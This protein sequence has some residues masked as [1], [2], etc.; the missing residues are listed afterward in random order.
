MFQDE[1]IVV[2]SGMV[3]VVTHADTCTIAIFRDQA[4]YLDQI[5][6]LDICQCAIV[7]IQEYPH[8]TAAV[9]NDEGV[10]AGFANDP[11][12]YG[13]QP[14]LVGF[15]GSLRS[16]KCQWDG[17][18]TVRC[19]HLHH[20]GFE[21][22]DLGVT[23]VDADRAYN[24]HVRTTG[25][26]AGVDI[27]SRGVHGDAAGLIL[28]IQHVEEF[29]VGGCDLAFDP[30]HFIQVIRVVICCLGSGIGDGGLL[31]AVRPAAT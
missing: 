25:E 13:G 15:Q 14:A 5:V 12:G 6:Q 17:I 1:H 8:R 7:A 21:E 9:I 2:N 22:F 23:V 18:V 31:Q 27:A 26:F 19:D 10:G 29:T 28:Y 16:G 3:I 4:G 20:F 30:D 24:P 11:A